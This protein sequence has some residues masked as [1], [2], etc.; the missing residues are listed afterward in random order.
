M[1]T[2]A[3]EDRLSA[4]RAWLA[5]AVF[6]VLCLTVAG[7]GGLTTTPNIAH[8]YAGLVKPSWTP[9]DWVFG[10]VWSVLYLSM[11]AAAWL[12]WR[13]GHAAVPLILFA[14]QLAFNA[15][16]PWLFFGLHSPGAALIDI[17]LLWAAIAVTMIAFW[18]RSVAAG[19]LLVPYL[20][21]VSFAAVL[22]FAIWRLN[23]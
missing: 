10:P 9:P 16:W 8:W 22:N 5:L 18:R 6:V 7:I 11:A 13:K 19:L 20:A 2:N 14:V 23:H 3:P 12:L 1:T 17:V 15:A 21:W 4:K